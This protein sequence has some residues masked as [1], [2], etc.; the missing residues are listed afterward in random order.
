MEG[1]VYAQVSASPL[2]LGGIP[3]SQVLT[4]VASSGS[5]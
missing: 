2:I 4:S 1:Q 5:I 3:E